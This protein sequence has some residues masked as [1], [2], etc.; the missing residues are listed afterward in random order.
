MY[1]VK[2]KCIFS[3]HLSHLYVC[4]GYPQDIAHDIFEGILPV[5]CFNVLIAQN[6]FALDK[7]N[8]SI[9]K[10]PY[11]WKDKSNRP[12]AIPKT[13]ALKKSI[14]GNAHKNW[15]LLWMLPFCGWIS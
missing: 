4:T 9:Q 3:A 1:G 5:Q 2:G 10:F 7:L 11:K 8:E 13:F 12:Q 14:G 15:G 6:C